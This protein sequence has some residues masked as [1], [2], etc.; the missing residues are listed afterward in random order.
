MKMLRIGVLERFCRNYS[1]CTMKFSA[2]GPLS[3]PK[4]KFTSF[5]AELS[6]SLSMDISTIQNE[7][8]VH[9]ERRGHL[10]KEVFNDL[11]TLC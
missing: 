5:G 1:L 10:M 2:G 11:L 9:E 7:L 6:K 8:L 3:L 4:S